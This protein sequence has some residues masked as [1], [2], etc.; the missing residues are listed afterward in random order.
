MATFRLPGLEH[1]LEGFNSLERTI[2][3]S[4]V[5]CLA[6]QLHLQ[7]IQKINWDEFFY[8][9]KIYD[10]QRRDLVHALQSFHVHLFGWLPALGGDEVSRI[11]AA[12]LVM[13]TLEVGTL[14][15]IYSTARAFLSRTGAL[16]SALAYVSAGFVFLHGTSFRADPIAA[17]LMMSCIYVLARS[18]LSFRNLAVFA[19]AAAIATLITIKVIFWAPAIGGLALWRLASAEVRGNMLLHLALTALATLVVFGVL[20][21]LQLYLLPEADIAQSHKKLSAAGNVTLLSA[22][23]LPRFQTIIA[24][25]YSSIIQS[26]LL[27]L[28]VGIVVVALIRNTLEKRTAWVFLS[29]F[30]P[31]LSF[32]FYR[33]AFPYFF[34]F[35][36]PPSMVLVGVS[37][38]RI[39]DRYGRKSIVQFALPIVMLVGSVTH[40]VAR[41][42]EDQ[43]VQREITSVI[44]Q[45]FPEP[46]NYID[47]CAMISSFPKVGFFM[48]SWGVDKYRNQSKPIFQSELSQK[49]VPLLILNSP[50]LTRAALDLWEGQSGG[51]FP[52]DAAT[53]RRNYIPHWGHI[54][55]AGKTIDLNDQGTTFIVEIPGVY[56]IESDSP[57]TVDGQLIEPNS[58]AFF[59]RGEHTASSNSIRRMVL[60]WGDNIFRP[61]WSASLDPP[62]QYF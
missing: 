28:G 61:S 26:V 40:Y 45:M 56:T 46:V 60:R 27:I 1:P 52:E 50:V 15:L 39:M 14:G 6:L 38:D 35:I 34:A 44:H 62:F 23:F 42:S 33:N 57:V 32:L 48:S 22:G 20:F 10:Y 16:V 37:V 59:E 24:G 29:M 8:L 21:A 9:S 36:F 58:T 12:R 11:K 17:F 25:M 19:V 41:L 51:L 43:S 47:R 7:F 13:W 54:W 5:L 30:A 18:E 3:I 55:V 2:L 53:L 49:T 4:I 31:L